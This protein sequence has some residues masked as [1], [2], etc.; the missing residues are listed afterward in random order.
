MKQ[1]LW[2]SW[3]G[4]LIYPISAPPALHAS[5]TPD[6]LVV[7]TFDD[8]VK[9]HRTFVAPLLQELGFGAT[10]FVTQRWM[11][12][13]ENFL[14]WQE[15][16]EIHAMGFEIGNHTWTHEFFS[17]PRAAANLAPDLAQLESALQKAG[18]PEP[19]SFAYPANRF[20]PEAVS[21]LGRRGYRFARRGLQPEISLE[22]MSE[23]VRI[24][25]AF[26]PTVHH[27]LLIPSTAVPDPRWT[28]DLLQQAVAKARQ[29]KIVVFQFHGVPDPVHPWV[30]F[31][32]DI[33][34]AFMAFLKKNEF[35]VIALRDLEEYLPA[36]A[37]P[38]RLLHE[39]W[40][41]EEKSR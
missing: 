16:A 15:I 20:G 18:V 13:R 26:D 19:V 12:D 21:V 2:I 1:R 30:D 8:A 38:D 10:F 6:K 5:E 29:G 40:P 23:Q 28:L 17:T 39:R 24:G 3:L 25:P 31:D 9:S 14:T 33:F 34:R 4:L 27:R 7:L 36:S 32:P 37:P 35:R 22:Q 11:R 41:A